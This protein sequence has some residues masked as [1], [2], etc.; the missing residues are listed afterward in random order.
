MQCERGLRVPEG[1]IVSEQKQR[2]AC[3][4][5]R[6]RSS[7]EFVV[8]SPCPPPRDMPFTAGPLVPSEVLY[9]MTIRPNRIS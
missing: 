7:A 2:V 1:N 3:L 4:L 9:L 8:G 6:M 5:V